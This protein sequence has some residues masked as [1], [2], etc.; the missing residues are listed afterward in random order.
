MKVLQE[1]IFRLATLTLGPVSQIT[2]R[3]VPL[4]AF[5]NETVS[6]HETYWNYSLCAL[7]YTN[8]AESLECL[9]LFDKSKIMQKLMK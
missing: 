3:P 6:A 7:N 9:K 5:E 4:L 8:G 2:L 1:L